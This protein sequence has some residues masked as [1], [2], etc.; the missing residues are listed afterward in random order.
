MAGRFFFGPSEED[1]GDSRLGER[2]LGAWLETDGKM[3]SCPDWYLTIRS[4]RYLNVPPWDLAGVPETAGH[5]CWQVWGLWSQNAEA[6][7]TN[8]ARKRA[9]QK[10]KR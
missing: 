6:K 5:V 9:S 8:A 4:A 10:A 7:A 1:D 2:E 3:G